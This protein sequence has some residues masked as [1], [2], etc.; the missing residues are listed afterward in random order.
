MSTRPSGV[1][2]YAESTRRP[3]RGPKPNPDRGTPCGYRLTDRM[4]FD[5]SMAGLFVGTTSLQDTIDIA[6]KE[7]LDRMLTIPGYR[8]ALRSAE[9]N[10]RRRADV[11]TIRPAQGRGKQQLLLSR[12]NED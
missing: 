3:R 10:Q 12:C 1:L 6:V 2:R 11:R 5:L 7:F 4:K 8:E 9:G